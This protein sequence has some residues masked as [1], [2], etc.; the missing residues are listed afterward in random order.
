MNETINIVLATD[1]NYA[2]HATVAM[3]SV[4]AN[5]SNKKRITFFIIN[6]NISEESKQKMAKTVEELEGNI[7]FVEPNTEALKDVFVSGNLTRA[8]YLRLDIPNILPNNVQKV[9]YLDCDLLVLQDITDLWNFDMQGNPVAATEDFGI[10]SSKG[11]CKEKV[12][13][14]S[15]NKEYSY[16]N[17]GVLL[18]DLEL[19]RQE[20]YANKLT[21]LVVKRNFR[22]HDQD[23]LNFL[24]MNNWAKLDLK[25]NVIPPIFNMNLK[26]VLNTNLRAKALVALKD[27]GII[28]YAG[29]YK[30][31][32]YGIH[33]GFNEK[34]YEYLMHTEFKEAV[35]PQPNPKKKGHSIERQKLRLRWADIVKTL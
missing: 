24:F 31:W 19:W 17:S 16:F 32:E 12:R 9:I 10:L 29:G 25:W 15:W 21:E 18:L 34:Y 11:K 35:M 22:H 6:D 14:L 33:K 5:T 28:H 8:A 27:M 7:Y 4:L 1:N 3:T 2:Q 30:P 13:N 23:A 20:N 26:V